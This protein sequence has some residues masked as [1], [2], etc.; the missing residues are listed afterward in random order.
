MC[1]ATE[2][3]VKPVTLVDRPKCLAA[4]AIERLGIRRLP[5]WDVHRRHP[6][7]RPSPRIAQNAAERLRCGRCVDKRGVDR[8]GRQRSVENSWNLMV[9]CVTD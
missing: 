3:P 9:F 8:T 7:F 5:D 4:N 2:R 6:L 1:M